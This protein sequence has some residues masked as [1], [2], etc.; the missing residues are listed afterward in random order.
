[1]RDAPLLQISARDEGRQQSNAASP[2]ALGAAAYFGWVWYDRSRDIQITNDA[3][4][5]GEITDVSSHVTGDAVE[6]MVDDNVPVKAMQAVARTDP[7]D[8]RMNV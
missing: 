2:A 4:M 8:F 3:Y 6:V 5:R 7:G 1:L